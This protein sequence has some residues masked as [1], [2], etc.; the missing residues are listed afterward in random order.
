MLGYILMAHMALTFTA[1]VALAFHARLW[2][3]DLLI[4]TCLDDTLTMAAAAAAGGGSSAVTAY[5]A[6]LLL[7]GAAIF[8]ATVL[9]LHLELSPPPHGLAAP[10][11]GTVAVATTA[12]A[13]GVLGVCVVLLQF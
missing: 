8:F 11:K 10:R 13:L 1:L 12:A 2:A 5:Y 7:S 4:T 6:V 9:R 3:A